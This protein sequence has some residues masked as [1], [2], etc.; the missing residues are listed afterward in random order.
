VQNRPAFLIRHPHSI[1]YSRHRFCPDASFVYSKIRYLFTPFE[2]GD[3]ALAVDYY[4]GDDIDADG[5]ES[6]LIGL[7]AVQTSIVSATSCMPVSKTTTSTA[8]AP[9]SMAS[10]ACCSVRGSSSDGP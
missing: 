6:N 2:I 5:D 10:T 1:L 4:Y 3:T 7:L 9:I 8:M